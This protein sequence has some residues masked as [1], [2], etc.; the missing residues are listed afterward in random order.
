MSN[1]GSPT[2]AR[3]LPPCEQN[4]KQTQ[5]ITFLHTP[6]V[7]GYNVYYTCIAIIQC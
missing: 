3:G 2:S 6:C 7:G 5:N 4:Y 1:G